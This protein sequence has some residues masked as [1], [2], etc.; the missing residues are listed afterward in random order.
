MMAFNFHS[1]LRE[2]NN[3]NKRLFTHEWSAVYMY[4]YTPQQTDI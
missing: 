4:F 1:L 3:L 2:D